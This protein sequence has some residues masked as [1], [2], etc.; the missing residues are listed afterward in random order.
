MK[1]TISLLLTLL[2]VLAV[3]LAS[4]GEETEKSE[5]ETSSASEEISEKGDESVISEAESKEE[6]EEESEEESKEKEESKAP[7]IKEKQGDVEIVYASYSE[8]PFG[9]V[10]GKCAEGATVYA[11]SSAGD[12]SEALSW[13]GWFAIRIN[14]PKA[15]TF[16]TFT[17]KVDGEEVGEM[18]IKKISPVTPDAD[19]WPIV[20]GGDSQLF[21]NKM[22]PDFKQTN[23]P[24]S[25]D[26]AN[27]TSRIKARPNQLRGINPNAEIIYMIVPSSMTVYP[28]LV[29]EEYKKGSGKSRLEMTMDAARNAG[30]TVIDLEALFKEHKNDVYPLY[31]KFDS[32]WTDYGA[33][34]AYTALCDHI[35][36]RFPAAKPRAFGEFDWQEKSYESGD[37]IYYLQMQR[38]VVHEYG[39]LRVMNFADASGASNVKRYYSPDRMTYADEM[40]WEHR[41]STGDGKK[42]DLMLIRDSYSTQL[43]D[44]LA[45]RMNN[46]HYIGM[47]SYAWNY[48]VVS[49]DQPDY[50]V[51]LVAEWNIDSILYS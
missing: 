45:E 17:Q 34:V 38:E 47:W 28:E 2:L 4:C 42:P 48:S 7:E 51:Y 32:H 14:C 41:F 20:T 25:N 18:T 19:M 8:K 11:E 6:S 26:I 30:A 23:L 12:S 37:M 46:S 35:S 36:E 10:V 39:A 22:L 5:A 29:P 24:S 27:F 16:Y 21:F 43:F 44:I 1:K 13:H 33:F 49:A 3:F 40:T 15:G 50:I 31:Y 9:A